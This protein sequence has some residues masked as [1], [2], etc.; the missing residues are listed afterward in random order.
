MKEKPRKLLTARLC[1]YRMVAAFLPETRAFALKRA[2]LRWC[3]AEVGRDV[4]I[5]SSATFFGTAR[6]VIG[7][8]VWIG[9]DCWISPTG[10]GDVFIGS[11]V[12]LGPGV[13]IV[14]GGHEMVA[15]RGHAAGKGC[16]AP[17]VI[18]DGCWIGARAT[19]LMGVNVPPMTVIA[20]GTLVRNNATDQAGWLWAGVPA[21]AKRQI[22]KA[23]AQG[24]DR[25]E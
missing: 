8:D 13:M 1:V 4:R 7:D 21:V 15:H 19:L 3:G 22:D 23:N 14:T 2:L 9:S 16:S 25:N 24:G 10:E 18:G 20:A 6:L 12:D 5:S 17:L 11:R